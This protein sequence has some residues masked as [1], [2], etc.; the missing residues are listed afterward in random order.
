ME[1]VVS[2]NVIR[3]TMADFAVACAFVAIIFAVKFRG[4]FWEKHYLVAREIVLV[5]R[6]D[7][8]E[9]VWSWEAVLVIIS[10]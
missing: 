2:G 10:L 5:V 9:P 7:D 6:E 1:K 4:Q 8:K 3:I